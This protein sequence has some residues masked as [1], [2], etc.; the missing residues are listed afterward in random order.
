M[1]SVSHLMRIDVRKSRK[2]KR[3]T[4]K[5]ITKG[6]EKK[7]KTVKRK[8]VHLEIDIAH[9]GIVI[10][11]FDRPT[12]SSRSCTR[13]KLYVLLWKA[14][15]PCGITCALRILWIH[16]FDLLIQ[17]KKNLKK[18]HNNFECIYCRALAMNDKM[19]NPVTK[20]YEDSPGRL[21]SAGRHLL[22]AIHRQT[23]TSDRNRENIPAQIPEATDDF[24][25][26]ERTRK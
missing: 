25:E 6:M 23:V 12:L 19:C 16:F 18:G 9:L 4:Y 15:G 8:N 24:F 17:K 10:H 1:P 5:K 21:G 26:V 3:R 2:E 22:P 20:F 14:D 13:L 11:R 7:K